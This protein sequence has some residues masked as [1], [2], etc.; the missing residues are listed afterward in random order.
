M[1]QENPDYN[2]ESP[3]QPFCLIIWLKV[4]L[5]LWGFDHRFCPNLKFPNF[6]FD[7]CR[8]KVGNSDLNFKI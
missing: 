3:T 8:Q 7:P 2:A 5:D 1:S 6:Q 4:V